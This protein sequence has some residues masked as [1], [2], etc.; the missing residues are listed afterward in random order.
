MQNPI[1]KFKLYYFR[2]AGLFVCKTKNFDE[3]Q[4]Q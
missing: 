1:L 4:L 3:L 2:E